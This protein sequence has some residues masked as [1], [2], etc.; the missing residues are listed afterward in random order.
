M[1]GIT[2]LATVMVVWLFAAAWIFMLVNLAITSDITVPEAALGSLIALL[3][4][5]ASAQKAFP[6][7]PLVSIV[8]LGGGTIILPIVRNYLNKRAHAEIDAQVIES[9]CLAYEFDPKNFGA[10][11]QLADQCYRNNLLEHAVHYLRQAVQLAPL[12][13]ASEKRKL[14]YWEEELQ[15]IKPMRHIPCM[16]C[17]TSN[18]IGPLRCARC[19]E[20]LLPAYLR[21]R[22]MPKRLFQQVI[23]SWIVSA[24][25]LA[26]ML[27]WTDTLRGLPALIAVLTT[28]GAA[29]VL[30]WLIFR[31]R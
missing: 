21:A 24:F 22:W 4:A 25:A 11:I 13:T 2:H 19:G 29:G 30:M 5:L 14:S 3:L 6:Y 23:Q 7:A 26:L 8:T 18:P 9:A 27:V 10:L 28:L 1:D 15:A 31:R 12:Y 20:L 16:V 17:G